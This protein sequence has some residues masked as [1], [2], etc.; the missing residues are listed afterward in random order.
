MI[1][2]ICV[3]GA[4]TMG[5]GIVQVAAQ[6]GYT[7]IQFDISE[8]MLEK[9]RIAINA[10]LDWLVSKQKITGQDKTDTIGE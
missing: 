3:C 10:N 1:Q 6:A 5:S 7:T 8:T 9:S 4:G 2:M